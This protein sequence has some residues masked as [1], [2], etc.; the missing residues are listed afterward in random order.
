MF[1]SAYRTAIAGSA[2]RV[3]GSTVS[4]IVITGTCVDA[5]VDVG[6]GLG[7]PPDVAQD[8][9]LQTNLPSKAITKRCEPSPM[10]KSTPMAFAADWLARATRTSEGAGSDHL[11]AAVCAISAN[12]CRV[13]SGITGVVVVTEL[14]ALATL[15]GPTGRMVAWRLA[16]PGRAS[17]ATRATS[18]T[19]RFTH[20]ASRFQRSR[21]SGG[22]SCRCRKGVVP[23]I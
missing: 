21:R 14:V 11:S 6:F 12:R 13:E 15:L 17:D 9:G 20:P 3:E 5:V 2:L 18:G 7:P 19:I 4:S 16:Q 23:H 1:T 8:G 22:G 10:P